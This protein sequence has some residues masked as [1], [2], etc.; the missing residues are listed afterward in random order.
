M[1]WKQARN[2]ENNKFELPGDWLKMEYFE[3]LNILFRIENSLRVFVY[4]ILKN[5]FRDK[6]RDLSL[7]SDDAETFTIGS[8]AKRRLSQDKDYAY[9]GFVLSSPL[10]HLTSGELIRLITSDSYWKLFKNYFMGSK[11]II[12]NKL[13]E[14]GN[15]RNSLAHFRPI[16]KGD[17]ELVKQNSIHTLTQ[18]E[19]TLIDFISCPDIVP[20]NNDEKWYMELATIGSDECQ[21]SFKQSKKEEWVKLILSFN[22]PILKSSKFNTFYSFSFA[23]LRTDRLLANYPFI[24]D[25]AI[26]ITEVRPIQ[27]SRNPE[28]QK[29]VKQIRITFSRKSL[30]NSHSVLKSEFENILQTISKEIDL[31]RNDNL[32]R[33]KLIEVV[34]CNCRKSDSSDFWFINTEVFNTEFDEESP[35]EFWGTFEFSSDNFVSDTNKYPWMPIEI[36]EDNEFS[37]LL[38]FP[39]VCNSGKRSFYDSPRKLLGH[40][41]LTLTIHLH[42]TH[43]YNFQEIQTHQFRYDNMR[44]M[45]ICIYVVLL[46]ASI[47]HLPDCCECRLSFALP[48]SVRRAVPIAD[49]FPIAGTS[50]LL[51]L[52]TNSNAFADLP[53]LTSAVSSEK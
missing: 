23:N 11:D 33:G 43:S 16:K 2:I 18:V 29:F 13:D 7:T 17:I 28:T 15:V 49:S 31:I 48:L 35:V 1:N 30:M 26:C 22:A 53:S 19:K 44:Q 6:W 36:S 41:Q 21:L 10:L 4:I 3:A 32:A 34:H 40:Q 24:T 52:H 46:Q 9:L 47:F 50:C 51:L 14:I 27:V 5:E 12:K 8:I 20:S 39:K 37:P 42:H 45:S 38:V 25:N